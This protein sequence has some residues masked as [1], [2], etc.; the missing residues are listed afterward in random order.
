MLIRP[1]KWGGKW[2][3]LSVA[4]GL[5]R[6]HIYFIF[7][8]AVGWATL[9]AK[10]IGTRICIDQNSTKFEDTGGRD[11]IYVKYGG[12]RKRGGSLNV[13]LNINSSVT[14]RTTLTVRNIEKYSERSAQ[15][16]GTAYQHSYLYT[17]ARNQTER[18]E[19][20]RRA[21]RTKIEHL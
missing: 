15:R 1:R 18:V 10:E 8:I 21:V 20:I 9:F 19:I 17:K 2:S 4:K 5:W 12:E 11:A 14:H 13:L 7:R 3:R 6:S 16:I